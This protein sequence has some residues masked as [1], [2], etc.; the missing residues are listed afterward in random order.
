M[1]GQPRPTPS[2]KIMCQRPIEKVMRDVAA[3]ICEAQSQR[4]RPG[5][6]QGCKMQDE[7]AKMLTGLMLFYAQLA[8]ERF[9]LFFISYTL[10][11][12]RFGSIKMYWIKAL[13]RAAVCVST[14]GKLS[15]CKPLLRCWRTHQDQEYIHGQQP[16]P[17]FLSLSR[18]SRAAN[19]LFLHCRFL[20]CNN[21]RPMMKM[22]CT[23]SALI[24][25]SQQHAHAVAKC[26]EQEMKS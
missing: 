22:K 18:P 26:N 4:R 14:C 5:F 24:A 9:S 20:I 23:I 17:L 3:A 19:L 15:G 11:L 2:N 12:Q 21:T 25:P 1:R 8:A 16:L 6:S 13:E 7:S 10:R